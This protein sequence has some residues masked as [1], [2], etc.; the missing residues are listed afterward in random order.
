MHQLGDSHDSTGDVKN[1]GD[2]E[3]VHQR[4]YS[5]KTIVDP[6]SEE[7]KIKKLKK[8]KEKGDDEELGLGASKKS[9]KDGKAKEKSKEKKRKAVDDDEDMSDDSMAGTRPTKPHQADAMEFNDP[10]AENSKGDLNTSKPSAV[11][12]PKKGRDWT[13]S[14]ALPGSFIAKYAFFSLSSFFQI[15]QCRYVPLSHFL[16]HL[17]S[18]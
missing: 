9:R 6:M 13:L 1:R 5:P 3:K 10:G 7:K 14:I 12:K 4:D 15:F 2:D 18:T 11:F 8:E 16:R 17:L